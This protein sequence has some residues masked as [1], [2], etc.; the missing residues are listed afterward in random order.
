M[1]KTLVLSL[2]LVSAIYAEEK[3]SFKQELLTKICAEKKKQCKALEDTWD[4]LYISPST[5]GSK[6]EAVAYRALHA[7]QYPYEAL[8]ETAEEVFPDNN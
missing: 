1:K 2:I 8:I 5:R 7:C 3:N 4:R 6:A